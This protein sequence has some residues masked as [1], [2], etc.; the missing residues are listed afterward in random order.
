MAGGNGGLA[1]ASQYENT[2]ALLDMWR[3]WKLS[4]G[5][6]AMGWRGDAV[7]LRG[8]CVKRPHRCAPFAKK[9]LY[10]DRIDCSLT[11]SVA[12]TEHTRVSAIELRFD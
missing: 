1:F 12:L 9:A 11:V 6:V 3:A 7:S 2:L 10:D 4:T 5:K 8:E